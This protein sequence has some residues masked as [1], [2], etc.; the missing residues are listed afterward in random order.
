MP[1]DLP[2]FIPVASP[3]FKWGELDAKDFIPKLESTYAKVVHWRKNIFDVPTGNAGTAFVLE[4]SCLFRAYAE[5]SALESI[6]LKAAL[7]MCTLLLQKPS[8]TS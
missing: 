7:T 8:R 1:P 3:V 2:D 6:A 5:G 4:L